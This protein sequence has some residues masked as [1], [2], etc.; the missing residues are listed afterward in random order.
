M[1]TCPICGTTIEEYNGWTIC[2]KQKRYVCMRCCMK[3]DEYISYAG[4]HRCRHENEEQKLRKDIS[5]KQLQIT[6]LNYLAGIAEQANDYVAMQMRLTRA[7]KIQEE[8]N[9]LIREAETAAL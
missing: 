7:K 4:L 1:I 3:C 2:P 6:R 8:V 9:V 5:R